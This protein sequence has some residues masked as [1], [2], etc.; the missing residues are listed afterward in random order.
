MK[1][2]LNKEIKLCLAPINFTYL[3][4]ALMMLIPNYPRYVPL[5]FFCVSIFHIFN[6]AKLNRDMEY[7]MILP[8]Q[9]KEMVKSRCYLI[10]AYELFALL[11]T[12]PL[13][14]VYAKLFKMENLAGIDGNVAFYGFGLILLSAFNFTFLTIY[15]KKADKTGKAFLISAIV[16]W[17]LFIILEFPIYTKDVFGIQFFQTLDKTDFAS[18]I[19][20]L[21]ILCIGLVVFILT[22][23][24]T[25]KISAKEFEK[26]D[27]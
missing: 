21:P 15:Y 25:Y 16:F 17:I 20:Q 2:F 22:W 14:I 19:H 3:A 26:V 5:F 1:N 18:Q 4:F 24:A 27:L 9:K 10:A 23:I 13:T 12:V 11:L 8:I 6:N 7:S